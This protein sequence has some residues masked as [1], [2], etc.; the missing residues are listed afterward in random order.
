MPDAA[1]R[2]GD[3]SNARN[4]N[5]SVQA[6]YNPFTGSANGVGRTQFAD[7]KIPSNLINPI[8]LK[9]MNLFPMPNTPGIATSAGGLTENYRR[10]ETRTVDRDNYDL[11]LNWNRSTSQQIWGKYSFMNAVVDDLTNY[12]G[13]NPN[14]SGDGGFTKVWQFTSG[15]PGR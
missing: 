15:R 8:S 5:G 2:A 12:L 4:T 14:A 7:N 3:F 10:D 1:L 9:I 13:P 6:I 11:K